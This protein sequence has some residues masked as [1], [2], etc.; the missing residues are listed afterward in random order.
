K[1]AGVAIERLER[2]QTPKGETYV[3]RVALEG[4]A[5]EAVLESVVEAALKALPIPKLMRW[6]TGDAEFVRPVHGLVMMHG[7]RVIPGVLLGVRSSGRTQ[8][9][10]FMGTGE[11]ALR[12]ADE[13][14][15]RL[16]KE[17]RVIPDFAKR[18]SLIEHALSE[19]AAREGA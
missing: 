9:H 5:L 13:Y 7:E 19:A 11:I 6:G 3:A 4:A 17:G 2:R 1:K 16:E 14:E 12:S 8:G 10:R 18:R 15:A